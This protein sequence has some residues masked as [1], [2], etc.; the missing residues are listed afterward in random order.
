MIFP[1]EVYK[2]KPKKRRTVLKIFLLFSFVALLF[3][4]F[5]FRDRIF[6][7]LRN[8]F[9]PENIAFLKGRYEK[10]TERFA[11]YIQQRQLNLLYSNADLRKEL[12]QQAQE[13]LHIAHYI[14]ENTENLEEVY[15]Y[16][17]FSYFY[18]A[19]LTMEIQPLTILRQIGE[20]EIPEVMDPA[21]FETAIASLKNYT[22]R[23]LAIRKEADPDIL[24]LDVFSDL[25]YF[26]VLTKAAYRKL[27]AIDRERL[28]ITV[29]PYYE[30]I[31]LFLYSGH[32]AYTEVAEFLKKL[33]FWEFTEEE[34]LFLLATSYF[35]A[36]DFTKLY[37]SYLELQKFPWIRN[38]EFSDNKHAYI[39]S[40]FLVLLAE[41]YFLQ[42]NLFYA[43]YF[44]NEAEKFLQSHKLLYYRLRMER[45]KSKLK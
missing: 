6:L 25:F 8:L 28:Q 9:L 41:A 4:A 38:Q 5:Y 40:G 16:L 1:T 19:V 12:I 21:G 32:G 39:Y 35:H 37:L 30:W 33:E 27:Q 45:L 7:Q 13:I 31:S 22:K 17:S 14:E 15:Y 18:V 34:N 42:K 11:G 44:L 10:F 36:K 26:K 23:T 24:F 29:K 3:G 20:R 43:K 2:Q